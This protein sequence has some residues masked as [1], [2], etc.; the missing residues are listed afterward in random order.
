[1][2][3]SI[4]NFIK[5]VI[6][7]FTAVKPKRLVFSSYDGHYS[8]SPKYISQKIHELAPQYEIIWLL[9]KEFSYD[10]PEY[11]KW[12]DIDTFKA[13]K[14]RGSAT[15]LID[16]VYCNRSFTVMENTIGNRLKANIFKFL[17]NKPNQP[18]F[19]TWH[20]TPIKRGGRDQIGNESISDFICPNVTMIV[21]NQHSIETLSHITFKKLNMKLI[22]TPRNDLLFDKKSYASLRKKL[23]LP[24]NK[25]MV[26]F[27]PTFRNDGRDVEG[28]NIQR[29]GLNQIKEID[30]EKLFETLHRKFGGEW[31][32]VCRFHYHVS[33]LVD[34]DALTKKYNG[35]VINGNEFD[36]MAE[37]LACTDLLIT[38]A[39]SC[40]L[41]YS[42]TQKPCFLFFPDFEHYK[43]QERGFYLNLEM[44]PFPLAM[45]SCE[46]LK[47]IND[48]DEEEYKINVEK[49]LSD[50]GYVD[51]ECSSKRVVKY[52]LDNL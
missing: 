1:M 36:E 20:G 39:S 46:L 24:E 44:L 48:F 7:K 34:W 52:I 21:G 37:Y 43:N 18:G 10:L 25:K 8:D 2:K 31:I 50:M 42:L 12:Y 5:A 13:Q 11:V 16:N 41:D 32:F 38:D 9:K 35:R 27:A 26:L 47:N 3:H 33:N 51:D 15:A 40:S 23:N 29:S 4:D 28:K 19:T 45:N 22:G 6:Y 14:I 49:M 17:Y 30:F